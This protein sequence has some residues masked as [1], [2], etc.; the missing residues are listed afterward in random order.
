MDTLLAWASDN[1]DAL[2]WLAVIIVATLIEAQT[3]VLISI[4]FIPSATVSLILSFCHVNIGIQIAVF[5]VMSFILLI[6]S[7]KL[8]GKAFRIKP[9]ATNSDSL[10][11]ERAIVTE[12][13]CNVEGK[14]AARVR[15]LEWSARAADG[16]NIKAGTVVLITGIEGVKLMCK[17]E[18]SNEK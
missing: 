6:F 16:E 17:T 13:I 3:L 18:N 4:W 5:A 14:G 10:I 12:D 8:F 11:G 9:V 15:G 2:V 1:I 7:R